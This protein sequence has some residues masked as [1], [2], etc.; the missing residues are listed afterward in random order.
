MTKRIE[1]QCITKDDR[2]D[3]HKRIQAVGGTHENMRWYLSEDDAIKGIE[4]STYSF[5]TKG[6]GQT[7]EVVVRVHEPSKRK[8]LRTVS[9]GTVKDNLLFLPPC[10]TG[11]TYRAP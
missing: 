1:I 3:I 8:Y 2:Q 7:A 9:D 11:S 10:P 6:G 5:W 4:N